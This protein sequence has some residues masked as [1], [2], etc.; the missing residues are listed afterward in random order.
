[1]KVLHAISEHRDIKVVLP[2]KVYD[3]LLGGNHYDDVWRKIVRTWKPFSFGVFSDIFPIQDKEYYSHL[4]EYL[5]SFQVMSVREFG[6]Y[7]DKVGEKSIFKKDIFKK[8]GSVVG[9]VIWDTISI[10]NKMNATVIAFGEKTIQL[11]SKFGIAIMK[12]YSKYKKGIKSKTKIQTALRFLIFVI[13][14]R[15]FEVGVQNYEI[16][17]IPLTIPE[18]GALGILLVANG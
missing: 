12:G 2:T 1:M 17:G 11:F 5:R 6:P 3:M 18:M 9:D 4:I 16:E 15:A 7:P 13:S 14:V 10:C 8:F